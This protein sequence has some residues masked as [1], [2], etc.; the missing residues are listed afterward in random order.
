MGGLTLG[1]VFQS[2][3]NELFGQVA[4]LSGNAKEARSILNVDCMYIQNV[5]WYR[6]ILNDP[7]SLRKCMGAKVAQNESM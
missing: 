1:G 3:L 4:N 6:S 7:G 5:D 2:P